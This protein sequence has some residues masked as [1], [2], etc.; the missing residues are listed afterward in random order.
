MLH[1]W[2]P[3]FIIVSV[4]YHV[5]GCRNVSIGYAIYLVNSSAEYVLEYVVVTSEG[6]NLYYIYSSGNLW[7]CTLIYLSASWLHVFFISIFGS[8]LPIMKQ[9]ALNSVLMSLKYVIYIVYNGRR[10]RFIHA[11]MFQHL[12]HN[13]WNKNTG[14][15]LCLDNWGIF[16]T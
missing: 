5:E 15:Q 11:Q 8:K 12:C 4:I 16:L 1:W 10:K 3:E 13:F 2:I 7:A 9:S 14:S 6:L